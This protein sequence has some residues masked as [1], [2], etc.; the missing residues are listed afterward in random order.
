MFQ[1]S[2]IYATVELRNYIIHSISGDFNHNKHEE[3]LYSY[4]NVAY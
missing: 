4:N 1:A 2:Y 3:V